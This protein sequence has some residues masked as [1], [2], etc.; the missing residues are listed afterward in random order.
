MSHF[1]AYLILTGPLLLM[2]IIINPMEILWAI[3]HPYE[4]MTSEYAIKTA[5][6]SVLLQLLKEIALLALLFGLLIHQGISAARVGF[7][8]GNWQFNL[9]IGATA[10]SLMI[11]LQVLLRKRMATVKYTTPD[12]QLSKG[13]V[14]LWIASLFVGA[15]AEE[16]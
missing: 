4:D 13:S 7:H 11:G 1:V 15:M 2:V 8:L 5:K 10:A 14:P 6:V 9:A 3:R 16:T 12:Q